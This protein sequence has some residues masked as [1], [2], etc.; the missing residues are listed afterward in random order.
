MPGNITL[1]EWELEVSYLSQ[2]TLG[3]KGY[4]LLLRELFSIGIF[5]KY[6][7]GEQAV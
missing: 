2:S 1:E 6:M 5:K 3:E 4:R 7:L